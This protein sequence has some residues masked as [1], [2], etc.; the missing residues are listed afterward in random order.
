[1]SSVLRPNTMQMRGSTL[2]EQLNEGDL[3]TGDLTFSAAINYIEI[4]NLDSTNTGT[5]TVNGIAI[6]VP[7][8]N[9][10]KD[11]GI[12][13]SVFGPIGVGGTA[14]ATVTVA[15]STDFIVNRYV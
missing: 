15:G 11:D 5:F 1:M 10:D 2:V 12:V 13:P 9:V 8:A 6:E 7:A 3:A 4:V 14:S